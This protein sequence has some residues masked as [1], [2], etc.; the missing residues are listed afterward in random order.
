[1]RKDPRQ[2][3]KEI[4]EFL[5]DPENEISGEE[6]ELSLPTEEE[7]SL[8]SGLTPE[9]GSGGEAE[10]ET[11]PMPG[12]IRTIQFQQ[13]LIAVGLV[14]FAI[15]AAIMLKQVK[16]LSVALISL[17]FVGM[18][19]SLEYDWM[20]GRIDQRVVACTH[21]ILRAKSSQI[22]CRDTQCVYTYYIPDKK[23]SFVEGYTYII[24]SRQSSPKAILAYQP[25]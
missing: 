7:F 11:E 20:K 24:W 13:L 19:L 8:E 9:E 4:Q 25:L 5:S 22:I 23:S 14:I 16:F 12:P 10:D 21:I 15:V 6:E 1:M 3:A 18:A 17:Y 2:E